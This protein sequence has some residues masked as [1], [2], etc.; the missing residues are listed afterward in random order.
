MSAGIATFGGLIWLS[1]F[2]LFLFIVAYCLFV[3][4][5]VFKGH[6]WQHRIL[7]FIDRLF[8]FAAH[9]SLVHHPGLPLEFKFVLSGELVAVEGQACSVC[10]PCWVWVWNFHWQRWVTCSSILRLCADPS[11][12]ICFSCG[13]LAVMCLA[14]ICSIAFEAPAT[15]AAWTCPQP[16]VFADPRLAGRVD[17]Y[18]S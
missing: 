14:R 17:R 13:L 9:H 1:R 6:Y 18:C 7:K 8:T 16:R 4:K 11:S 3:K 5:F 15:F 10:G 12:S 2:W